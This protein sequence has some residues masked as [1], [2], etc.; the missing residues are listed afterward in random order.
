[1]LSSIKRFFS[2]LWGKLKMVD[3]SGAVLAIVGAIKKED[4]K[5]DPKFIAVKPRILSDDNILRG[6]S[7]LRA[8]LAFIPPVAIAAPILGLG[9]MGFNLWKKISL[10]REYDSVQ[11]PPLDP[12]VLRFQIQT[13]PELSKHYAIL[14]AEHNWGPE[15]ISE[16]E[17][18]FNDFSFIT[19]F[20]LLRAKY[21]HVD[22]NYITTRC[23]RNKRILEANLYEV[24]QEI[25]KISQRPEIK[26]NIQDAL[27]AL[28]ELFPAMR[29]WSLFN[30]QGFQEMIETIDT[31]I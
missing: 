7:A 15:T 17:R 29:D 14:T 6:V 13:D 20:E 27:E 23:M 9:Q 30:S 19:S 26:A 10:S 4:Y 5:I 25:I 22:E 28:K 3:W 31:V 18:V 2:S 16:L 21:P 24:E 11:F 8:A 12:N 1:M